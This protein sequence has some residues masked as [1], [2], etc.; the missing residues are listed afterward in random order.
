MTFE[1]LQIFIAVAEREHLTQ[2]A[3]AVRLTPSAVSSSIRSLEGFY[4]VELFHRVGR[5]IE[6]TQAGRL[7]LPEA[8]AVV[9]RA[10]A[11]AGMLN[12]IGHLRRGSLDIHASQTVASYWLPPYLAQFRAAYP[13]VDLE[14][15]TA[16]TQAVADAVLDGR[17]DLGLVEGRIDHG[18]LEMT[19]V[20]RDTLVIVAAPSHDLA[21][22]R[23]LTNADLAGLSWILRE[24]GSGTRSEFEAALKATGLAPEALTVALTLPSN[25]AVL[26]AVRHGNAATAVSAI[27]AEPL[28]SLR[29]V[30]RLNYDLPQR[31]FYLLRHKERHRTRTAAA[32]CDLLARDTRESQKD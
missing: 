1:Q 6:L 4:G 12:D 30:V 25:E 13:G 19:S 3:E 16:N 21:N 14:M 26:S 2:A 27:A 15:V 18:A 22:G 28:L 32:F 8:K 29:A 24:R 11:A 5:R 31:H 17:A 9:A 7:F 23:A 10:H 20:A